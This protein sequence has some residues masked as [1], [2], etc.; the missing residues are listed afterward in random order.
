[1]DLAI[2]IRVPSLVGES[3]R[4]DAPWGDGEG[5]FAPFH[6]LLD[7]GLQSFILG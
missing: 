1:V 4:Y 6:E 5:R 2:L 7:T 3:A